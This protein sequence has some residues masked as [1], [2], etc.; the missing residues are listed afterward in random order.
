M[1]Y[2]FLSFAVE[3][4]AIVNPVYLFVN[5]IYKKRWKHIHHHKLL[6]VYTKRTP[7]IV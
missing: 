3:L 6:P 2:P 1:L 5:G 7:V 4:K